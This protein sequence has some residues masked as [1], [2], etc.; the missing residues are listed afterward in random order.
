MSSATPGVQVVPCI[1]LTHRRPEV[2]PDPARLDPARF[3]GAKSDPYAWFPFGGGTRRCHYS[4]TAQRAARLYTHRPNDERPPGA[5]RSPQ[6]C[7]TRRAIGC[8]TPRLRER[9]EGTVPACVT[10]APQSSFTVAPWTGMFGDG[11]CFCTRCFAAP[12]GRYRFRV[13]AC[14]TCQSS[15]PAVSEPF[16]LADSPRAGD[17]HPAGR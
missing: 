1:Y 6:G 11:Q 16:T 15:R 3:L 7:L 17:P 12:A 4:N 14:A 5:G 2:Y 13:S 8:P 10:L 9:C